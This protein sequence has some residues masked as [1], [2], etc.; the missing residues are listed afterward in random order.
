MTER[1]FTEYFLQLYETRG[2]KNVTGLNKNARTLEQIVRDHFIIGEYSECIDLFIQYEQ[3]GV[4]EISCLMNF[5][6]PDLDKVEKSLRLMA[7][8]ILPYFK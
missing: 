2:H 4:G 5:G 7:K 8:H 6:S 1:F 3:L